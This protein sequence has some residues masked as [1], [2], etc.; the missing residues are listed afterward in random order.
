MET[1]LATGTDELTPADMPSEAVLPFDRFPGVDS[2]LGPV[3]E[4]WRVAMTTLSHERGGV[5]KLHLGT[6]SKVGL[7]AANGSS[8]PGNTGRASSASAAEARHAA[9]IAV[10]PATATETPM[11]ANAR[12]TSHSTRT[13]AG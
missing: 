12:H 2:I 9:N 7:S 3:D 13:S 8:V 10:P 1:D 4:G 5:A 11:S 6:R